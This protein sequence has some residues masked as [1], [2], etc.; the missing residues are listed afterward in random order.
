MGQL[1][2]FLLKVG[3]LRASITFDKRRTDRTQQQSAVSITNINSRMPHLEH[4]LEDCDEHAGSA[5]AQLLERVD[6]L[7]IYANAIQERVDACLHK[8][9]PKHEKRRREN[10]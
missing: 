4:C 7:S 3:V 9:K 2:C 1:S 8:Q 10:E 6:W 5:L